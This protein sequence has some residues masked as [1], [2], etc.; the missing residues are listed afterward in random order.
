MSLVGHRVS[1]V[2]HCVS[3][4]SHRHYD[5]SDWSAFCSYDSTDWFE[6]EGST[7]QNIISVV[8]AKGWGYFGLNPS[9]TNLAICRQYSD[10]SDLFNQGHIVLSLRV[11]SDEILLATYR[12]N[13]ELSRPAVGTSLPIAMFTTRYVC[14]SCWYVRTYVR[15]SIFLSYARKE[16]IETGRRFG[17]SLAYCDTMRYSLLLLPLL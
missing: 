10:V 5:L 8:T 1:L 7:I 9:R 14:T 15:V 3:L 4:V 12:H 6:G 13:V 2:G 17:Q 11:I 16:L